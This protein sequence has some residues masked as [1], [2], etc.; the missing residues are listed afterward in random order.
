MDDAV[1]QLIGLLLAGAV[2]LMSLRAQLGDTP[3]GQRLFRLVIVVFLIVIGGAM[4]ALVRRGGGGALR[5]DPEASTTVAGLRRPAAPGDA[6]VAYVDKIAA[7]SHN[8]RP[9]RHGEAGQA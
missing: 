6:P 1:P 2:A 3:R 4:Y 7:E 9:S 5:P 8:R